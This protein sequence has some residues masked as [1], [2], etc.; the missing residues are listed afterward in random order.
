[1]PPPWR[2]SYLVCMPDWHG[3]T[4]TSRVRILHRFICRISVSSRRLPLKFILG[5]IIGLAIIP[6]GVYAYFVSGNAPVA[7]SADP[8]P[9]EK[10]L[11]H[12]ALDARIAKEA[13]KTA[14]MAGDESNY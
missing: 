10:M 9:F 2:H 11:A 7:T 4:G 5:L 3:W 13:P 14:P 12:K 6:L 8:M 1:M